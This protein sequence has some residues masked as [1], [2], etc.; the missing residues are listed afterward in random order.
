MRLLVEVIFASLGYL[1]WGVSLFLIESTPSVFFVASAA[2]GGSLA[3]SAT[4]V[5][6]RNS[7]KESRHSRQKLS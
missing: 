5:A 4:G 7:S 1:V 2:F 6:V 3:V